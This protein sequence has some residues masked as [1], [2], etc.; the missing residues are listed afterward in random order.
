[1]T[2]HARL[3]AQSLAFTHEA[4][5]DGLTWKSLLSEHASARAENTM[6]TDSDTFQ[7]RFQDRAAADPDEGGDAPAES[8]DAEGPDTQAL[9]GETGMLLQ[10][11]Q[12]ADA[13]TAVQLNLAFSDL[14]APQSLADDASTTFAVSGR[15]YSDNVLKRYPGI[16]EV[17][18]THDGMERS[19]IVDV[20]AT[21]DATR[22]EP[23]S[24]VFVFHG[25][26]GTA[27]N[28]VKTGFSTAGEDGDFIVVYPQAI[29]GTWTTGRNPLAP[30][31]VGF[32]TAILDDMVQNWNVDANHTFAAG[33]SNGGR[34][35]QLLISEVPDA[36]AAYGLVNTNLPGPVGH[37]EHTGSD[38][39]MV[40]F[41]GTADPF[42]PY[43]GQLLS[44]GKTSPGA[45]DTVAYWAE[46]NQTQMG[47]YQLLP[48][49]ADDGMTTSVQF[50]DDGSIAHYVTEGG[51]HAWPGSTKTNAQ[52]GP[53]TLDINAT[54]ILVDFFSDYGL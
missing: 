33:H 31:D 53:A 38:E 25:S 41:H 30:D 16:Q 48:D 2:R 9:A 34:F 44:N 6:Q 36:F 26:G 27:Q 23:Y 19:Y 37:S 8:P 51:G 24:V 45:D 35:V 21:F 32:A 54:E 52:T 50:S 1:M 20:P 29:G 46:N 43:D 4:S 5:G 18:M 14:T 40:I 39:P 10:E 15:T 12:S 13:A 3:S 47:E 11:F 22:P 28:M 42:A 17:K 7:F 49:I